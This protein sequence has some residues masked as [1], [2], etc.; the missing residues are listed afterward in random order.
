MQD[1]EG[2]IGR[3]GGKAEQ[4][5][6]LNE[7]AAAFDGDIGVTSGCTRNSLPLWR[8]TDFQTIATSCCIP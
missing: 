3:Y 2:G 6:A 1:V 5:K 8:K 7:I 4:P